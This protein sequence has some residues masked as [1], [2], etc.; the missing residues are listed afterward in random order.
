MRDQFEKCLLNGKIFPVI[1]DW[2]NILIELSEA[3]RD[4]AAAVRSHQGKDGKWTI[5][6]AYSSMVHAYRA[7][8]MVKGYREKSASCL[9]E[10]IEA[11]Y[12]EEGALDPALLA[13]FR[14]ARNLHNQALYDGVSSEP[15][16]AWTLRSAQT[17]NDSVKALI[18]I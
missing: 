13:G 18:P 6:T 17:L 7:L 11:L 3:D 1:P 12:V 5:I 4:L 8:I 15:R 10:A 9:I 16:A 2:D 14:E